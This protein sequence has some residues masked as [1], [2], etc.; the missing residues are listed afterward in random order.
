MAE[1]KIVRLTV[2]DEWRLR[3]IRLRALADSPD[4]FAT[5]FV[6]ASTQPFKEWQHQL[7]RLATFIA[8]AGGRDIGIARGGRHDAQ[9][10]AAVLMSMWV[11]PETRR[12]GIAVALV[13]SVITWARTEGFGRLVLEVTETNAP[14]IELYA[15]TGFVTTGTLGAL[16]PPR[17]HIR[18]CH[19]E[20]QL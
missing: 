2:G 20:L 4:A 15:N 13:D 7:E 3:E 1:I 14:A 8:V 10:D 16:P 19:M 5:T 18:E 11:A 12:Q 6:E 9:A 17:E